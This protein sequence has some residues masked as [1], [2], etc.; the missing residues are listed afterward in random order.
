MQFKVVSVQL[1][2][3]TYGVQHVWRCTGEKHQES[4]MVRDSLLYMSGSVLMCM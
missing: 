3:Y 4:A 2:A 1:V